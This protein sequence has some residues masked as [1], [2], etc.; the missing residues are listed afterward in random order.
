MNIGGGSAFKVRRLKFRSEIT[1]KQN[2]I[3][4]KRNALQESMCKIT[5]K[6]LF[7]L[8]IGVVVHADYTESVVSAAENN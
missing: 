7:T 6:S 3:N 1:E 8:G 4:K 2:I 5:L